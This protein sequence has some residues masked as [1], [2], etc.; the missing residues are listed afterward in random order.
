S[1]NDGNSNSAPATFRFTTEDGR[2]AGW[3]ADVPPAA[4]SA[5]ARTAVTVASAVYTGI[6]IAN[7]GRQNLIYAANFHRGTIDVFDKN[8]AAKKLSGS[9]TDPKLPAGYA[10]FNVQDIGGRLYVTYAQQDAAKREE[11][12]GG[13]KGFVDRFNTNGKLLGR[14][15]SGG[16]LNA[17]WGIVRAPLAFG[18]FGGDI[19]VGNFGDGHIDAFRF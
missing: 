12:T 19:L 9:F 18:A 13:G 14:L 10:P 11:I 16:S 5:V 4:A 3:N 2:I 8:F 15:A 7:N 17:P 6:A 1:I